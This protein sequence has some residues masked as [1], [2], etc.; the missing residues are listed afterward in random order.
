MD[1]HVINSPGIGTNQTPGKVQRILRATGSPA[2]A[3]RGYP[4]SAVA[5]TRPGGIMLQPLKN[6]FPSPYPI[7]LFQ[8]GYGFSQKLPREQQPVF[9]PAKA[10]P[11]PTLE[12]E[13]F[14]QEIDASS[15]PKLL[16][17]SLLFCLSCALPVLLNPFP[18]ILDE[19][20]YPFH[21]HP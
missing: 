14:S 3:R 12:F 21:G 8:V 13:W 15:F 9:Q 19:L 4:E 17:E 7:P 16:R 20:A 18:V 2:P 11:V 10:L 5:D 6:V 1:N